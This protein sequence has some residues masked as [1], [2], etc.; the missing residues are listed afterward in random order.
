M[1]QHCTH[2]E[3]L[4]PNGAKVPGVAKTLVDARAMMIRPVVLT[5]TSE[6]ELQV[7]AQLVKVLRLIAP[8]DRR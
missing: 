8:Y 5:G 2:V 6:D 4:D 7:V 1:A 3:V